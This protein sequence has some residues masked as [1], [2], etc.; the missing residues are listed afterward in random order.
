MYKVLIAEDDPM[1]AMINEKYVEKNK[2]Y[3][4]VGKARDGKSA[5]AFV[6]ENEVDL[7]ILDVYMPV[8]DGI[9]A[10][11]E[12]RAEGLPVEVIMVTAANDR[13]TL[14]KALHMGVV[15]YLVKPF[16]LE[17]FQMALDKFAA[18]KY[19]FGSETEF[20]QSLIDSIVETNGRKKPQEQQALPKGIQARTLQI[21]LDFLGQNAG[22]YYP[23]DL[24]AEKTDLTIV[25]VRRYMTFLV[26]RGDAENRMNYE[27]GGRP[28]VLYRIIKK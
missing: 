14:E 11:G 15:D 2:D 26:E 28:Q 3:T 21:L 7:V 6:K 17:R 22:A 1:V 10:L 24:I 19:A 4:V 18:Q 12:M 5:V 13:T 9:E 23:C 25:T 27:T 16:T 8:M 20:N